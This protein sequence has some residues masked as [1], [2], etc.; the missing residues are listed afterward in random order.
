VEVLVALGQIHAGQGRLEGAAATYGRLAVLRPDNG[1]YAL[2]AGSYL[3]A[4]G[5]PAA[6]G[7]LLARA[8]ALRPGD[9][10]AAYRLGLHLYNAGDYPQAAAVLAAGQRLAP[11]RPDVALKLA[12][13][14]DRL[15]RYAE[16]L[17]VIATVTA[18][19]PDDPLLVFQQGLIRSRAGDPGGAAADFRR[20]LELDPEQD[21]ARYAL[22]RALLAS[23][24]TAEGQAEMARFAAAEEA[25]RQQQTARLVQHLARS[26]SDDAATFRRQLE[27]LALSDPDNAEAQR[28][29]AAAYEEEGD[30][31]QAAAA[32]DRAVRLDPDDSDAARRRDRLLARLAPVPAP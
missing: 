25:G 17:D 3:E 5:R 19:A 4:T 15:A 18:A 6:A 24:K 23:G 11:G 22:A 13:S 2:R 21:R 10:D 1:L 28:L 8:A 30:Y 29:L 32:Y 31:S 9:P 26:T 27:A 7:P 16:A 14:L 12:Q 20:V